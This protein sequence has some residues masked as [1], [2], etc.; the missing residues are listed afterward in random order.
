MFD[1][2]EQVEADILASAGSEGPGLAQRVRGLWGEVTSENE[3]LLEEAL[4]ANAQIKLLKTELTRLKRQIAKLNK[5]KFGPSADQNPGEGSAPK[6]AG[7]KVDTAT[8]C[9]YAATA[10][11][12]T[13]AEKEQPAKRK[14]KPRN[15]SGRGKRVWPDFLEKRDMFMGTDDR[16]CP[17]GCGGSIFDSEINE[18]L[19]VIP[20]RYYVAVREYPKYR[21]RRE[22]KIVGT[23]F[24]PRI[25]PNTS[26]SNRLMANAITMRFS[27]QLPWYRQE[28]I[29]NSQG[30][31]LCRSTL[32]RWSNRL[33]T[34]A[35]LPIYEMMEKELK[36][37]SA[38]LFMD[39]TTL[40]MLQPGKGKTRTTYMYALLRDDR[41]FG[42]NKPPI[43]IYYP[44][45]TRAMH[46]IHDILSGVKA[47]VQSDA[48]GGYGRLGMPG[49]PVE[50]ITPV[51]CWAHARRK[52]TDEFEFNKTYDAETIINLIGELYDEEE[53]IRGKPP[54]IRQAHRGQFSIPI[55]DRLRSLLAEQ[56][57][58]HLQKSDMGRA[59]RYVLRHWE[60]LT[61]FVDDGRID[62]DTNAVERMFKPTILLRKN[63]LFVGSDEGAQAWG[64]L[65]SM[66]ET[67]KLN[68]VNAE[69]YLKWVFDQITLKTPRS[70]YE[71][72]LPWNAPVEFMI[73]R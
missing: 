35:L 24:E 21:C 65:S 8:N 3:T 56:W 40:P 69:R 18:T 55:L 39:E 5:M 1:S 51:K 23:R 60:K 41:A 29:F 6:L 28:G 31:D 4:K 66:V 63:V 37:N 59:I 42:G 46:H 10:D 52:F 38:R 53:K 50:N 25:F 22:D 67:C 16:K 19:E 71:K 12:S 27:W 14:S 57:Q 49:T 36:M 30:I 44:R 34:E 64:I 32:M 15:T 48:Y 13:D 73:K 20:A 43:V 26:I 47:I 2:I 17:C 33:A 7:G 70:K 11:T 62:L 45:E 68:G 72:L 54:L 61:R 9:E 58:R